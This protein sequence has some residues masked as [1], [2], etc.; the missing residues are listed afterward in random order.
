MHPDLRT[1]PPVQRSAAHGHFAGPRGQP[2]AGGA[3]MLLPGSRLWE[4]RG[5]ALTTM[6]MHRTLPRQTNSGCARCR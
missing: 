4:Q 3:D 2:G 6:P 1:V 5:R